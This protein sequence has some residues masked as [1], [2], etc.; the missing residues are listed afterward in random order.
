MRLGALFRLGFPSAPDL[1]ALN[2]ATHHNSP[3]HFPRGTPSPST[4]LPPLP[5]PTACRHT[6]SGLFHSPSGVLFTFP[7][8]YCST[9]GRLRYL[10]LDRG[11]PGFRRNST[12]SA[13]L[14]CLPQAGRTLSRTGL[15][16][17]AAR[18]P[19][20]VPLECAFVTARAL[21]GR[22]LEDPATPRTQRPQA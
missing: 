2:L 19:N 10:A 5:A 12:C 17:S 13:L 16:P 14:G 20:T 1:K 18:F 22:L 7:S 11:R 8:R 4:R 9:I 21:C 3:A 15:S 6:V